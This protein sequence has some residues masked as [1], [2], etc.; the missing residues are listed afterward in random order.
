[1]GVRQDSP[2]E[3][4]T[5]VSKQYQTKTAPAS[6]TL[7]ALPERVSVAMDEIASTRGRGC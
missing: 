2:T 4:G 3:E 6:E 7:P 1:M 5:A